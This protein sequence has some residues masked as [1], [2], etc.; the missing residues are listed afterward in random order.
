MAVKTEKELEVMRENAKIHKEVFEE[1][2]KM[3]KPGVT[4]YD[5]D[6]LCGEIAKKYDVLCGFRGVYNFPANICI[7]VN[8]CVVHGIPSRNMVFEEGDVVKFDF[9][10]KD[11]KYGL[12]TDAAFTMIIGDG[13][14]DLEVERFLKV[15][16]EAL[17][18]GIAKAVVG[19]R[20]G[21]IGAAIQEHVEK[22]GYHIVKELTG[23]GIGYNLHEKPYI[24]NCG[25]AGNGIL[26]KENM[27]LAIEPI[28]GFS[29]GGI[30]DDGGFEIYIDDGSLGAQF[31]HTICVKPGY[32]EIII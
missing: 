23:H 12:N 6:K 15:S 2:K 21:D 31:E 13:P 18:K 10:I 17:Y 28:V 1:I 26:L 30:A 22:N 5:V 16:Q 19:N 20:V 9:G 24:P 14:H 29:S 27:T 3:V 11:K 25:R 4:G 8:D 7:S 32:P